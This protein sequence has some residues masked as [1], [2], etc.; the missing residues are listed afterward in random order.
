MDRPKKARDDKFEGL[1][2]H[3]I[4]PSGN[5]KAGRPRGRVIRKHV[6]VEFN[7]KHDGKSGLYSK[8]SLRLFM[9][10]LGAGFRMTFG[11]A[12]ALLRKEMRG[13]IE[14]ATR[15]DYPALRK[16]ALRLFIEGYLTPDEEG[17][18]VPPVQNIP[19][20]YRRQL[21]VVLQFAD[22]I[23][24]MLYQRGLAQLERMDFLSVPK[25][26]YRTMRGRGPDGV[27][28]SGDGIVGEGD[29]MVGE[30]E[31]GDEDDSREKEFRVKDFFDLGEEEE[32]E[33]VQRVATGS[34]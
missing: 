10:G 4:V 16:S 34:E 22:V 14:E 32:D 27:A 19:L 26:P 12:D 6:A 29:G 23:E 1:A 9:N 2:P 8:K 5:R 20:G 30:G 21:D 17:V 11:L 13:R 28:E 18:A 3:K 24:T 31:D 33:G 15:A 7:P 25:R